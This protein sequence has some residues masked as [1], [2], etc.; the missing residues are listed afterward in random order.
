MNQHRTCFKTGLQNSKYYLNLFYIKYKNQIHE[1]S[2]ID[3]KI[4][5]VYA[6]L[7][8]VLCFVIH[9]DSHGKR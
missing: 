9:N 2:K 4:G 5:H 1:K 3:D 7:Q 6:M 8:Y